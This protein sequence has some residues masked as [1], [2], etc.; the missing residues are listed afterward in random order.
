MYDFRANRRQILIGLTG[1]MSLV[2]LCSTAQ[3]VLDINNMKPGEFTWHPEASPNG[4]VAIIVSIPEQRVHVYR[5][6][7]RIGV[8]TC[9]TGKKGHETPSGVFT[10]LQKDKHHHS[11]KYNNA[12]MPN[13]NRLTWTGIAMHA[14]HL[15]GYP[16]SHGCVR[17][18]MAFSEKLFSVTHVGTP[19]II[20]GA[21]SDPWQLVHPGLLLTGDNVN[22]MKQA[23]ETLKGKA[24][25]VFNSQ[26]YNATVLMA[27]GSDRI[28][29]LYQNGTEIANA[30]LTVV[31][32]G[33][34][35]QHVL[36]LKSN[37][38]EFQWIGITEYPDPTRPEK[39]ETDIVDRLDVPDDFRQL[40]TG[41]LHEGLTL[42][43]TDMPTQSDRQSGTGFVI[44]T[45]E[46]NTG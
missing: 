35:G 28:V 18:P 16:A 23:T 39:P 25:K 33:P 22:E 31:G 20:S 12:P 32:E 7:I 36:T 29:Y 6:G 19:V 26:N 21:P 45:N 43:V 8:S 17:L 5:N 44:M 37:G 2:P 4:V 13:M 14:G 41:M 46:E 15:P 40:V 38:S 11:N 10:I 3:T 34:L 30:P 1:I 24:K 42:I 27:S 9:S